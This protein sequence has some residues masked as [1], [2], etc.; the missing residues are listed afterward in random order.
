MHR[1]AVLTEGFCVERQDLSEPHEGRVCD[2]RH[3]LE[4]TKFFGLRDRRPKDLHH[5]CQVTK[6][7]SL[8]DLYPRLD[9]QGLEQDFNSL[10][11]PDTMPSQA[12]I[13]SQAHAGWSLAA[14]QIR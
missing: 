1:V 4:W 14:G 2:H 6:A 13:R 11:R 7:R 5:E 10:R 8:R 12:Y 3:P 9:R